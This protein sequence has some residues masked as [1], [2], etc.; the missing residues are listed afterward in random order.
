MHVGERRFMS[1]PPMPDPLISSDKSVLKALRGEAQARPPIWVMRQAGRYLPEYRELRQSAPDFVSFCL[2]PEMA[3]EATLQPLRRFEL[4]A[5]ILFADILLIPMAMGCDLRFVKGEGPKLSP[6]R[7]SA[8]VDALKTDTVSQTLAPVAETVVRVKEQL[9]GDVALIGF[10]GA[11]WTVATYMIE[12]EGSRDQWTAR[13]FAYQE[14]EA[15]GRLM[16]MLSAATAEYLVMQAEAGAEVLKIFDSWASGLTEDLFDRAVIAPTADIV[17]QVRAAGVDVPIIGF[18]RGAGPSIPRYVRETGVNA[19]ALDQSV[20]L[21][22]ARDNVQPLA[23]VQGNLD[24]AL[25]R[26]GG[27][28]MDAA[29]DAIVE[30]FAG[31]GH[32]FN[33]GHGI[34]PETPI[35]NMERLV[36]RVRHG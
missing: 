34:T 29:V 12:G 8:A 31:G 15:F 27:P 17:R 22:W 30:A 21:D 1:D 28:A 35:E 9:D 19:V 6:V 20:P 11:P 23:P 10:A 18:P 32:V 24:N 36:N 25:L 26:A 33:L 16:S 2:T 4:S 3:A 14:P 7:S 13:V 5:A